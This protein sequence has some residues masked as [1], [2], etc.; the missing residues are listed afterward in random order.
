M[1]QKNKELKEEKEK[2]KEGGKKSF[3]VWAL[4]YYPVFFKISSAVNV[5]VII[6]DIKE[7]KASSSARNN[8]T[9]FT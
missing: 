9:R 3:L 2:L 4:L 8:K 6:P 7:R 5:F 1:K